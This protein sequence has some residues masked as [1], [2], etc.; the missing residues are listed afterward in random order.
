MAYIIQEIQYKKSSARFNRDRP[1]LEIRSTQ[2][3]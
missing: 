2:T 1:N 3:L